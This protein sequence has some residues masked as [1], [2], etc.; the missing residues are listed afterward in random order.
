MRNNIIIEIETDEKDHVFEPLDLNDKQSV[1]LEYK[2][3]LTSSIDKI[4]CSSSYT[5]KVPHTTNNDR[6]LDLAKYPSHNSSMRYKKIR[7][8]VYINGYDMTG[9]SWC[10]ITDC[11][12]DSYSI[13]VVFGLLQNLDNWINNSPGL[14]DLIKYGKSNGALTF[15]TDNITW[16]SHSGGTIWCSNFQSKYKNTRNSMYYGSYNC[17]SDNKSLCN[18]HPFVTL[19]EIYERI[20]NENGLLFNMPTGIKKQMEAIGLLLTSNNTHLTTQKS[21]HCGLYAMFQIGW[22]VNQNLQFF[23]LV[24]ASENTD[25]FL[26]DCP[27]YEASQGEIKHMLTPNDWNTQGFIALGDGGIQITPYTGPSV[28]GISDF[29]RWY[30]FGLTYQDAPDGWLFQGYVDGEWVGI[31]YYDYFASHDVNDIIMYYTNGD[32]TYTQVTAQRESGVGAVY[33]EVPS[34]YANQSRPIVGQIVFQF[35]LIIN[36]RQIQF[37]YGNFYITHKTT[38]Y[39]EFVPVA[40]TYNYEENISAYGNTF[41]LVENLPDMSQLDFIKVLCNMFGL[42][43]TKQNVNSESIDFVSF[44]QL[45]QKIGNGEYYD[46]SDKLADTGRC[47]AK[48]TSFVVSGY[49]RNNKVGYKHDENDPKPK[50]SIGYIEVENE[51]LEKEKSLIEFPWA[52]SSYYNAD[53]YICQ[54]TPNEEGDDVDFHE[55]EYRLLEISGITEDN[56]DPTTAKTLSFPRWLEAEALLDA[57]YADYMSAIKKPMYLTEDI[58]LNEADVRGIDNTKPVYLKKYGRYFAIISVRWSSNTKTS[59]VKLLLL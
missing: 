41:N 1:T 30:I 9:E 59:E 6:I 36:G 32:G 33:F 20:V 16:D 47:N 7:C 56:T 11:D 8:H 23:S 28:P 49:A 10:Y 34:I 15:L 38:Y 42:F 58:M 24:P 12:K 22:S 53:L 51:T 52:A 14:R 26:F 57:Y 35:K 45:Y 13:V 48:K 19:R 29:T 4:T 5:I 25:Y 27:F 3:N 37:K 40:M 54:Y 50:D 21:K 55:L 17:G 46:W 43:A 31:T 18:I 44:S 39:P 2:S